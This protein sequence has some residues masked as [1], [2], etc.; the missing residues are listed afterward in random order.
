MAGCALREEGDATCCKHKF[1]SIAHSTANSLVLVGPQHHD[2]VHRCINSPLRH[3]P[4][5]RKDNRAVARLKVGSPFEMASVGNQ[6]AATK[7]LSAAIFKWP[8]SLLASRV[9]QDGK[10]HLGKGEGQAVEVGGLVKAIVPHQHAAPQPR[11]AQSCSAAL[12]V[13][14]AGAEERR[15]LRPSWLDCIASLGALHSFTA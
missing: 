4:G 6:P 9:M 15:S 2:E 3:Q 12:N 8:A 7:A 5:L 1:E 11:A 14:W 13:R 10:P